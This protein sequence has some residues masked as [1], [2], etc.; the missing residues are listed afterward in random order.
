VSEP[1]HPT[2]SDVDVTPARRA[3]WERN[4]LNPTEAFDLRCDGR[5]VGQLLHDETRLDG[6][7][8]ATDRWLVVQ[9]DREYVLRATGA[10]EAKEQAR[11]F[12]AAR[13]AGG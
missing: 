5:L 1:R 8:S 12:V 7:P 6:L 3:R 11:R 2:H 10:E 9:K 4:A 13:L